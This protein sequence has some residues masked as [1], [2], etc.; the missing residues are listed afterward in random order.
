M[1]FRSGK[2]SS[3]QGSGRNR[4]AGL[5]RPLVLVTLIA[6][7]L[8]IRPGIAHAISVAPSLPYEV[9]GTTVYYYSSATTPLLDKDF[10]NVNGAST[11]TFDISSP[12]TGLTVGTDQSLFVTITVETSS[13]TKNV[14]VPITTAYDQ[15]AGAN[16]TIQGTV[17]KNSAD[18]TAHTPSGTLYSYAARYTAGDTLTVGIK[19]DDLCAAVVNQGFSGVDGCTGSIFRVP[20]SSNHTSTLKLSFNVSVLPSAIDTTIELTGTAD[21]GSLILYAN[22]DVPSDPTCDTT[23]IYYPGDGEILLDTNRISSSVGSGGAPIHRVV[24]VGVEGAGPPNTAQGTFYTKA[25]NPINGRPMYHVSTQ[26]VADF[27]NSTA[28]DGSS[29]DHAYTVALSVRNLA[30]VVANFNSTTCPFISDVRTA[31]INGFLPD[32]RCFIASAAFRS[33]EELPVLMLREFRDRVLYHVPGGTAFVHAYY[34]YGPFAAAW[35]NDHEWIRPVVLWALLPLQGLAWALLHFLVLGACLS[36]AL[37]CVGVV[38]IERRL[39]GMRGAAP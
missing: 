24:V 39:R 11:L 16:A 6:T 22:D 30:G 17:I 2:C 31:A 4:F 21:S 19:L 28:T 34:H 35:V 38:L 25:A 37:A 32:S 26:S 36:L 8:I 13:D 29:G 15:T 3:G 5:A 27:T 18:D 12:A 1:P 33:S 10:I 9:S 20:D 7:S 23:E 14:F